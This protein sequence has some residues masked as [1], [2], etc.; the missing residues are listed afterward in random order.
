[1]NHK[2]E[3]LQ[4][5]MK[6]HGELTNEIINYVSQ[7]GSENFFKKSN[8]Q[9]ELFSLADE[10]KVKYNNLYKKETK[11]EYLLR[12]G[13]ELSDSKLK[14]E[15]ELSKKVN[16][17][18]WPYGAWNDVTEKLALEHGYITSSIRGDKNIFKKEKFWRVDRIALDNP[19]Y[20]NELFYFYAIY[21]LLGYKL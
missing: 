7:N 1:M 15:N 3:I 10:L 6:K 20:Q 2:K 13:K 19:K 4:L 21:K 14:I 11:E 8:W 17:I 18:C 12:I 5:S 9:N 16:H